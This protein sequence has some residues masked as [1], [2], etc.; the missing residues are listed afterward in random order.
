MTPEHRPQTRGA[1]LWYD[2][3]IDRR[4]R[5]TIAAGAGGFALAFWGTSVAWAQAHGV[6]MLRDLAPASL[7]ATA[8]IGQVLEANAWPIAVALGGWISVFAILRVTV[9]RHERILDTKADKELVNALIA[10]LTTQ[11]AATTAAVQALRTDYNSERQARAQSLENELA[12]LRAR[13]LET[14][15]DPQRRTR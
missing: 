5:R 13:L 6:W 12:T 15:P 1:R 14:P 10:N 7:Q 4:C 3:V 11:S 8:M 9:S 2:I